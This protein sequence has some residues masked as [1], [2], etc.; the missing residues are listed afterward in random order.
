M[1]T[2][3]RKP[4]IDPGI[5]FSQWALPG[6]F[7][8]NLFDTSPDCIKILD[9]DGRLVMMNAGGIAA[10]EIDN[11]V[12]L[13]GR[14]WLDFVDVESHAAVEAALATAQA[15]GVG[16]FT[17][18]SPTLKGTPKWWDVMIS[19]IAG[20]DG[21]PGQLLSVARDVT[22]EHELRDRH[23][24]LVHELEHRM[25]NMLA[26]VQSLAYQSFRE[27]APVN[28]AR[29]AFVARLATLSR[30]YD[31]L[32]GES[33]TGTDLQAVVEAVLAPHR[34]DP[35][36]LTV[37]GPLIHLTA[38][39]ATSFALALHELA[40]NARA[41]GALS[42]PTGRLEIDWTAVAETFCLSWRESDGPAVTP[43]A[44]R[45][46]G[47]R[48]VEMSLPG[49]FQGKLRYDFLPAGVELELT[50]PLSAVEG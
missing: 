46:F 44:T 26:V 23:E 19:P 14:K 1:H 5:A 11:I 38:Q 13:L 29:E 30:I 28:A 3:L 25:K 45:G 37:A 12:P 17:G 34:I 8:Y 42:A 6:G 7:A 4:D 20:P 24:A 39:S 43:P 9:L 15:G 22:V 10:L 27:G 49:Q 21:Q 50:A 40:A 41:Y 36:Q 48:L 32:A 18:R 47:R 35:G 2:P 16:R 31:L 33:W